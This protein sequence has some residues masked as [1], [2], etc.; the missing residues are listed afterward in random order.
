MAN[1]LTPKDLI[2]VAK[3]LTHFQS[4]LTGYELDHYEGLNNSQRTQ[5]ELALSRLASGAGLLYANAVQLEFEQVQPLIQKMQG[6]TEELRR[7]LHKAQMIQQVLDLVSAV[8]ALADAIV[9]Q[10]V[11][12]IVSG[13][14]NI[15]QMTGID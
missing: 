6:A 15:I 13:I 9:S 2:A 3:C 10:D 5:I 4:D 7:F 14:D 8:A 1:R 12:S 11:D